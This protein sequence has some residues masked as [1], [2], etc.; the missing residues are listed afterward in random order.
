MSTTQGWG[1]FHLGATTARSVAD[2]IKSRKGGVRVNYVFGEG[3]NPRLRALREGLAGLGL[4]E[5]ALLHHGNPKLIYGV[6]LI[7]NLR[8]YLLGM[9]S[10]PH[11]RFS[12]RS[13]KSSTDEIVSWWAERWLLKRLK[14]SDRDE[15]LQAVRE[16]TLVHPVMHGGRVP[17]PDSE[18]GQGPL[19]GD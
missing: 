3:A 19:F 4:D 12:R 8:S 13:P 6:R 2:Y 11:Y 5:E 15:T 18:L 7:S 16:H 10:K 17:L 14:R 9:D 1:T